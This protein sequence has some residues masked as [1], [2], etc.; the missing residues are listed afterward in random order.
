M[1]AGLHNQSPLSTCSDGL[2]VEFYL[3][4]WEY[5][6]TPLKDCLNE[7]YQCGE[8][9]ISLKRG[10]ISLLPKRPPPPKKLATDH[11]VESWLQNSH[12]MYCNAVR[13]SLARSDQLRSNGLC[14]KSLYW[15]K[16]L[17]DFWCNGVLWGK[18]LARHA[19]FHRFWKSVW[20]LRMELPVQS[21][22]GHELWP[23]VPKMDPHLLH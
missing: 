12:E 3:C 9:S 2:T 20:F 15:R 19:T 7:A 10:V 21:A 16:H 13:E 18:N 5:V 14:K 17:V 4:F 1:F 22:R 23:D 8:M 6:A 11:V